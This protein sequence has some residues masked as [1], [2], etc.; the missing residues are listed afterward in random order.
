[1]E[2]PGAARMR[3]EPVLL[4]QIGDGR[5]ALVL[6]RRAAPHHGTFVEG[7]GLQPLRLCL[8]RGPDHRLSIR[9]DSDSACA[10]SP[11]AWASRIAAGA[12]AP[13]L[14]GSQPTSVVRFMK[15]S[16]PSP[17]AKRALRAVGSTWFG[18]AM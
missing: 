1:M 17:E 2:R 11:S 5:V 7:D 9:N 3:G 6:D 12:S 15:S 10:A 4:Q 14:A 18:P 16:T 8:C 13:R